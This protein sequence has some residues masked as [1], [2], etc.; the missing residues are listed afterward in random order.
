MPTHFFVHFLLAN[1][2][3]PE[4]CNC[5]VSI[6]SFQYHLA[7]LSAMRHWKQ[8]IFF[9]QKPFASTSS[10]STTT[11]DFWLASRH[12]SQPPNNSLIIA[13]VFAFSLSPAFLSYR[14]LT[15]APS[16]A[17]LPGRQS[18]KRARLCC[19]SGRQYQIKVRFGSFEAFV[20]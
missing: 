11:I 20:S 3:L 1:D 15:C 5:L 7:I 12:N 10:T 17:G 9:P 2:S 6:N 14:T 18:K 16:Q 8:Q 4:L 19:K 13:S